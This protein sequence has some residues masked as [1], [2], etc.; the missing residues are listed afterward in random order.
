MV[1]PL[2]INEVAIIGARFIIV[3]PYM[4][5]SIRIFRVMGVELLNV[6]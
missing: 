2:T 5:E 1:L 3:K 4:A 6:A